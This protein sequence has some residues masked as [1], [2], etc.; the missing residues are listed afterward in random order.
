MSTNMGVVWSIVLLKNSPLISQ[1]RVHVAP[2]RNLKGVT[3]YEYMIALEWHD[4]G[5]AGEV[6]RLVTDSLGFFT[7]LHSDEGYEAMNRTVAAIMKTQSGHRR[8]H[9]S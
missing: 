6:H 5:V 4:E 8:H 2:S 9:P 1:P 3:G 7:R